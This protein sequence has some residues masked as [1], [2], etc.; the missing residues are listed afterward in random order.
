MKLIPTVNTVPPWLQ[1][2]SQSA[3]IV[4]D[5]GVARGP[6]AML[7]SANPNLTVEQAREILASRR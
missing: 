1:P 4:V 2:R 7:M 5:T 6:V 3:P